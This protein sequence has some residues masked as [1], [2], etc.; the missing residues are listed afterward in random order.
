MLARVLERFPAEV[1]AEC[2]PAYPYW[3]SG[4]ALVVGTAATMLKDFEHA[5]R[6]DPDAAVMAVNRTA[7]FLRCDF[8]VAQDRGLIPY[9]RKL[10]E[11]NF[12]MGHF[13]VH[14]LRSRVQDTSGADYC[15]SNMAGSGTTAWF[16]AKIA[17]YIGFDRIWLCGVAL[18]PGSYADGVLAPTFDDAKNTRHMQERIQ[19]DTWL[20]PYVRALSGWPR[21]YFG[22][23]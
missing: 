18:A 10:Q 12:G 4:T 20:H 23:P 22:P 21:D 3:H 5:K 14:T 9:W 8:L 7:Q 19:I 2:E 15:W 1:V 16:A 6:L 17:A 11:A 13:S